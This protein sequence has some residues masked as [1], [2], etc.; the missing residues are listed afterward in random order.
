M[1]VFRE[2]IGHL[3]SLVYMERCNWGDYQMARSLNTLSKTRGLLAAALILGLA[4]CAGGADLP[5]VSVTA[6]A[7]APKS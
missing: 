6:T 7:P 2:D 4:A 5:P 1:I 3:L